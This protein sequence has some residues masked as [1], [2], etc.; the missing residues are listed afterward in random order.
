MLFGL[1]PTNVPAEPEDVRAL[2]LE[3]Q[4]LAWRIVKNREPNRLS[5]EQALVQIGD[6]HGQEAARFA[7]LY[8]QVAD[9][10]YD[11]ERGRWVERERP[12]WRRRVR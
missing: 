4:Q 12:E 8:S 2:P 5:L 10:F 11:V 1:I 9:L 6:G 3:Q 7:R